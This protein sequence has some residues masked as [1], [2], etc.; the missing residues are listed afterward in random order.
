MDRQSI[1]VLH[2]DPDRTTREE[3]AERIGSYEDMSVTGV[4]DIESGL[5]EFESNG[6]DCIV[7]AYD[8][9]DGTA[10]DLFWEGRET[11]STIGCV[12]FTAEGIGDIDRSEAEDIVVEYLSKR[13]PGT[14]KRLPELVRHV[15]LDRFQ[16]GYPVTADENARL[17]AVEEYTMGELME[18]SAFDRLLTITKSHFEVDAAFVGIMHESEEEI[19]ACRGEQWSVLDRENTVC[20]YAML[21]SE[22]TVIEDVRD[23][24]RFEHNERLQDLGIRS[25]AGANLR[26]P[27]GQVIGELC[28][29]SDSPRSYDEKDR[30]TLRLFAE[31]VM[32]QLELRRRLPPTDTTLS[33]GE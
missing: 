2:V 22:V 17:E 18:V 30:K 5:E 19:I 24:P 4:K 10:F 27:D 14:E 9:P 32:E 13:I 12:L 23:D 3:V 31:E 33:V 29:T 26:T 16:V 25:Y 20:T 6:V 28:L 7:A 15:V 1:T 21:D 11:D 8:L